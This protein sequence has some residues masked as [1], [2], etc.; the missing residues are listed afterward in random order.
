[1]AEANAS[2]TVKMI[3]LTGGAAED[4][5]RH[6]EGARKRRG[7]RT[8][9]LKDDHQLGGDSPMGPQ[10]SSTQTNTSRAANLSRAMNIT[11]LGGGNDTQPQI[12]QTTNRQ[13]QVQLPVV[14]T[15]AN[16]TVGTVAQNPDALNT[17]PAVKA[18][19][20]AG[21]VV[22]GGGKPK[23]ILTPKKHK[24]SL[25][26]APPTHSKKPGKKSGRDTRKIKVQ[27]SNM[28][29]RVTTAKIIHKNSKDKS[30][31]EIRNLL[32]GAKLIKPAKE[33]KKVPE[34]ILRNIYKDYLILRNKAL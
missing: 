23:T 6:K 22:V 8:R 28:K 33:G 4:Y 18:A 7:G 19:I 3:S 34:D 16:T 25:L 2:S 20:Q 32:E 27:L 5:T 15:P 13:P 1:M 17:L 9:K 21:T 24:S 12:D 29:K 26:L 14:S 31:E 10:L 30:I 11:K